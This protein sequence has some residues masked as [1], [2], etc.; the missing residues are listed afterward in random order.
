MPY[1]YISRSGVITKLNKYSIVESI[2]ILSKQG[3]YSK[4]EVI[5][6][7]APHK[8]IVSVSGKHCKCYSIRIRQNES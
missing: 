6:E 5:V 1:I 4:S 7:S 3:K 8:A 2:A